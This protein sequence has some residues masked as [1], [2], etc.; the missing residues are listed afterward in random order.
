[1]DIHY[2]VI[3]EGECVIC[4]AAKAGATGTLKFRLLDPLCDEHAMQLHAHLAKDWTAR[5]TVR[6]D[7]DC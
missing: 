3:I 2:G 5:Q 4:E 7:Q 1:M 6:A